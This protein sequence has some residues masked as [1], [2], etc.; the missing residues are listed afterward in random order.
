V[1]EFVGPDGAA[2]V[3]AYATTGLGRALVVSEISRNDALR[4]TR[5]LLRGSLLFAAAVLAAAFAV[6]V[7]FARRLTTPLE[8]LRQAARAVAE[9][10][11]DVP[12]P[13][14]SHDEIGELARTFEQMAQ[15]VRDTQLQLVQSAKMA[16][17][18]QMGAGVAHEI[19]NPL[20]AI[21]GLCGA[22]KQRRDDP[23]KVAECLA[24]IEREAGR[25]K[26]ILDGFL[27]FCRRQTT[28]LSPTDLN[29]VVAEGL[30][31]LSHQLQTQQVRLV[32]EL[33]P[34]L[35]MVMANPNQIHQVLVNL[36]LNAQQAMGPG[37]EIR[38][39]TRIDGDHVEVS[40]AAL[41][42]NIPRAI[43]PRIFE[44]FFT[45]KPR[46][47][48]TGLGL[49]V[50]WG[51]VRDHRGEIRVE[52]ADGCGAVFRVRLPVVRA[53]PEPAAATSPSLLK[54]LTRTG[55]QRLGLATS[56][57]AAPPR[58]AAPGTK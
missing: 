8:R 40:V 48:G 1:R 30:Q 24:L 26:E 31:I 53:Q 15:A 11:Y 42:P 20:S 58:A 39:S 56:E 32:R 14:E 2:R 34:T 6:G 45:T 33:A 27:R 36:V 18:G 17:F 16:A 52:S 19:K 21:L 29:H 44:P 37:G 5:D 41:S 10:R 12:V 57:P 25:C 35:P 3:G 43:L 46:G 4:G 51:I 50:S 13:V 38:V 49:S 22:A 9:G 55:I 28:E 7:F 47:E 23:A 54:F